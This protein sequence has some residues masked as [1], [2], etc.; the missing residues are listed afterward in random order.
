MAYSS[1]YSHG[2]GPVPLGGWS[3]GLLWYV[4]RYFGNVL[5]QWM[6]D[7]TLRLPGTPDAR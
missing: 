6:T 3:L 2:R 7:E 1:G 4:G 5:G